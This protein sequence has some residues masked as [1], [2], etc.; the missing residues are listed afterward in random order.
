LE[1]GATEKEILREGAIYYR[2][3]ASS[4]EIKYADLSRPLKIVSV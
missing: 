2:Y 1:Q 3:S 4:D